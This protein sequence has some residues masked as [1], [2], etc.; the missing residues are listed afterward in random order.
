MDDS[1]DT[2]IKIT[3]ILV[4]LDDSHQSRAALETAAAIAKLMEAKIHGLFVHDDQW[5]RISKLPSATE[6]DELTGKLSP[7]GRESI[8]KE[9]FELEKSIKKHFERISNQYQIT[10]AWSS[11]KG[12][13]T[14]KVLE[15]AKE[16]DLITIG[17]KGRSFSKSRKLG[18][19]AAAVIRTANKPVLILQKKTGTERPTIVLFDGSEKSISGVKTALKMAGKNNSSLVAIDIS[20][21]NSSAPPLES[22][23]SQTKID[24]DIIKPDQLNMGR[25]LFLLSRLRGGFLILP[26]NERFTKKST[27]EYILESAGCPILL[28]T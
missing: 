19:T 23:L 18:S 11:V 14:E 28:A 6:I 2:S 12:T 24:V 10:H 3:E 16:A 25:F 5:L 26:K 7:I 4:A 17:S 22:L 8:E 1:D 21:T 20:D 9:I 27:V 15:A 13:V